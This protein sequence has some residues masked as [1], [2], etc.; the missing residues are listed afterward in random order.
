MGKLSVVEP[1]QQS[2]GARTMICATRH[3]LFSHIYFES[4]VRGVK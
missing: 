3:T 4:K 2:L 1:Q